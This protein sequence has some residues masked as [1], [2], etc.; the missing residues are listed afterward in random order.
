[1]GPRFPARV[2]AAAAL[3]GVAFAAAAQEPA[4]IR[5]GQEKLTL[6]LGAFLPAWDTKLRVD[7][8]SLGEGTDTDLVDDLGVKRENSG[9]L[10]GIEWR[11]APRHRVGFSYSHFS[12]DASRAIA[13][14]LQIGD[15]IYPA[16]A[17]VN[18]QLKIEVIPIWYSYSIVKRERDELSLSA[19]LHWSRI[20]FRVQG[21]ASLGNEDA[22]AEAGD[23][24]NLPL[25]LIGLRYDHHFSDRWSAGLDT[26]VFA[27]NYGEGESR[28]KGRLWSAR[29]YAEYRFIRNLAVGAAIEG[30]EVRVDASDGEWGGTVKYGYWGPQLYLKARF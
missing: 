14:E 11:F 24:G 26:G 5:P 3:A 21:S 23:E 6:T 16:G 7:N 15:E 18:T 29:A 12:F 17:T 1:M 8:D 2:A 13:R 28:F 9:V 30:F 25:P 22:T 27:I 19:G 4:V 20:D 10:L